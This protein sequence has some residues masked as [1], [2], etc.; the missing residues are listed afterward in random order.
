MTKTKTPAYY[1]VTYNGGFIP[2]TAHFQT[3]HD[4]QDHAMAVKSKG[5][6]YKAYTV[7]TDGTQE[8]ENFI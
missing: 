8:Q 4:M 5:L 3:F 2:V 1:V 6:D 7:F